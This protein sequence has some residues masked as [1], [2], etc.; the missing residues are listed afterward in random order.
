MFCSTL[1]F[2][3]QSTVSATMSNSD[4]ISQLPDCILHHILSF[5][6][7]KDDVKTSIL[8]KRWKNLWTSVSNLDFDDALLYKE[9]EGQDPPDEICFMN[10]VDRVLLFRDTSTIHKFRLSC[11]VCFNPSRIH[12]WISSAIIHNVHELDLCLFV[13]DPFLLPQSI[14]SSRSLTTLKIEMNCVLQIPS[15]INFPHLKTLHLSLITFPDDELTQ[16]L[17][18]GCLVLE[19]LVL[20]DCEWTN[21]KNVMISSPNLKR[22]TID[23]LPY[24]GPP[25]D[26]RGCKIMIDAMNLVF[27]KYTGYLSNEIL[28]CGVLKLVKADISVSILHERQKE[29]AFHVVDLLNGIQTVGYLRVSKRTIESFVFA[30]NKLLHFPVFENLTHLELSME[31]G[32][33][34]IEA[35]MKFLNSCPNVQSLNFTEGFQHD[36]CLKEN[37]LTWS[38]LPKSLKTL[39]FK[40]FHGNDSE[41]CF[42]KCILQNGLVLDKMN[43]CWCD[44]LLRDQ[45]WEKEVKKTLKSIACGSKSCGITWG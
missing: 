43:I 33:S 34:T 45:K 6:P 22:L 12:S 17:F 26:S 4:D 40:N 9:I 35:L 42:L 24:F 7:T 3:N 14:F 21:L 41:I 19:E 13:E 25:D 28:L 27:F 10:F 11:R 30:D 32:N 2:S 8:S 5:I 38:T 31:I 36:M 15:F 23:D 29:V 18:A 44:Y 16:K 1:P 20:L 37:D 39:T